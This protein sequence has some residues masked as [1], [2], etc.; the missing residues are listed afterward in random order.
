[1]KEEII[2]RVCLTVCL[3]I[4]TYDSVSFR[5]VLIFNVKKIH[6]NYGGPIVKTC[7]FSEGIPGISRQHF[8]VE[9]SVTVRLL[10]IDFIDFSLFC[11]AM[12]IH[13]QSYWRM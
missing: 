8:N 2:V 5:A 3:C 13:V 1:M 4:F 7:G 9:H 10:L 6:D 11:G 12:L